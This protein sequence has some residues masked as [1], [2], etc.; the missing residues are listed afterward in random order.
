MPDRFHEV[1][2]SHGNWKLFVL[3]HR[4]AE[5]EKELDDASFWKLFLMFCG[6]VALW[7]GVYIFCSWAWR[8]IR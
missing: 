7:T 6:S 8:V 2:T 3:E 4:I 5:T 1:P